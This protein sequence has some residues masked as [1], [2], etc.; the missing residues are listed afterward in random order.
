MAGVP[1]PSAV[2]GAPG[3][4]AAPPQPMQHAAA[5][6]AAPPAA[7]ALNQGTAEFFLSNYRLG[8]TLG[9]GSF[10][11]VRREAAAAAVAPAPAAAPRRARPAAAAPAPGA[12]LGQRR[13]GVQLRAAGQPRGPR[14]LQPA[15][16]L[17]P[18]T[19]RPRARLSP[20]APR[21]PPPPPSR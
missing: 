11:K 15:V 17:A 13:P 21:L 19:T 1:H 5:M 2:H 6:G 18:P 3:A 20:H 8:K 4:Y 16:A 9:I 10:G 12:A 14:P 7:H